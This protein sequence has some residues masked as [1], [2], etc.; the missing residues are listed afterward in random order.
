MCALLWAARAGAAERLPQHLICHGDVYAPYF[1]QT[2]SGFSG[3]E[4][5]VLKAAAARIGIALELKMTPFRRIQ[6]ELERSDGTVDCAFALSHT[7]RR[8][9]FLDFGAQP[10]EVTEYT[11]FVRTDAGIASLTHLQGKTIGVRAGFRLPQALAEGVDKQSWRVAE[12]GSDVANF[13]KLMFKRV[14]AVLADKSIGLYTQ[15]QLGF[16][17]IVPIE[18]PLTRFHTYLVFKKSAHSLAL[19][20]AFDR[21]FL[22]MR[23][24]GTMERLRAPYLHPAPAR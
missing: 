10:L 14:D 1:M 3:I 2:T 24:D 7:A 9:A 12:T 21:A 18:P 15:R 19:A 17:D 13:Q 8:D 4:V 16:A 5:D 20:G 22:G 23:Q 6:T 11:L